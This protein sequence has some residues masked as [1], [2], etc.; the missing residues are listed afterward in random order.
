MGISDAMNELE[1]LRK[2]NNIMLGVTIAVPILLLIIS[3]SISANSTRKNA[4]VIYEY[5]YDADAATRTAKTATFLPF[6]FIVMIALILAC[7]FMYNNNRKRFKQIYKETFVINSLANYFSQVVYDWKNGFSQQQVENF[8]LSRLGNRFSS[9]DY[10]RGVYNDIHFAQSDV[11]IQYHSG[12]GE[13][14]STTTYFEGRMFS[15]DFPKNQVLSLQIHSKNFGYA[16][17]NPGGFKLE[18]VHM[19][20]E[21]FNKNFV[22]KTANQHDAFYILTPALMERIQA[23][24]SKYKTLIMYFSGGRLCIGIEGCTDTFDPPMGKKL[25]YP[26]EQA[27]VRRDVQD[28]I[29]VIDT[30]TQNPVM[31]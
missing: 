21:Y 8:G 1:K 28:I 5:G 23:L 13:N 12:N 6:V 4:E 17:K 29:D 9:E 25:S 14:S 18:K 26:D 10:L 11:T 30:M 22:V 16:Q 3:F 19:E 27:R 31:Q 20:S 2:R 24:K 7:V 15:F